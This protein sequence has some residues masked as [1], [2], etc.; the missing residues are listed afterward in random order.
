MEIYI[1]NQNKGNTYLKQ[2]DKL[3]WCNLIS[4]NLVFNGDLR[5]FKLHYA[6]QTEGGAV[7]LDDEEIHLYDKNGIEWQRER[8]TYLTHDGKIKHANKE[9]ADEYD[10]YEIVVFDG[11]TPE[12]LRIKPMAAHM[13]YEVGGTW[14]IAW[15][16]DFDAKTDCYEDERQCSDWNRCLVREEDGAEHWVEGRFYSMRLSEEQKAAAGRFEDACRALTDAG[17]SIV[18]GSYGDGAYI[19]PSKNRIEASYDCPNSWGED[20]DWAEVDESRLRFSQPLNMA[21]KTAKS[22]DDNSIWLDIKN[23]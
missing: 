14:E 16:H 15:N 7:T 9:N 6:L 17:L 19:I 10:I 22:S 5:H 1:F 2:G 3:V 11:V 23:D 4:A 8:K 20:G 13:S 21:I 18:V 12:R